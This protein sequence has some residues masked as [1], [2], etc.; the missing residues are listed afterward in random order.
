V[1]GD[2]AR[3]GFAEMATA[4]ASAARVVQS[5]GRIIL[6]MRGATDL[7]PA[8]ELIRQAESAEQALALLNKHKPLEMAAA[9]LWAS[10]AQSARIYLLSDFSSEIVEEMFAVP[11]DDVRQIQRLLEEPGSILILNDAHKTMATTE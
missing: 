6:L 4:A 1:S 7:G 8:G 10:A 5:G 11:L 2:P 3:L 9:F